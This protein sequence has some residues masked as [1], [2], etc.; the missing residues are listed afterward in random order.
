MSDGKLAY[1][2]RRHYGEVFRNGAKCNSDAFAAGTAD[3]ALDEETLLKLRVKAVTYA[4]VHVEETGDIYLTDLANFFDRAKAPFKN[5][6]G[7]GGA[8][9]RYLPTRYF[10]CLPGKI[11]IK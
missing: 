9:Q 2:A 3:W 6:E 8:L 1:L 7:R 10:I 11:R 5:Y 4:G